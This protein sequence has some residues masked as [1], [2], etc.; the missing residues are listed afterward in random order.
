M[1]SL[2][3]KSLVKTEIN[4]GEADFSMLTGTEVK[5]WVSPSLFLTFIHS[6]Y[7]GFLHQPLLLLST[8]LVSPGDFRMEFL[9][10]QVHLGCTGMS[11]EATR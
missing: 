4:D 8:C 11:T 2:H 9:S 6:F 5:L 3:A 7:K 1:L 10:G